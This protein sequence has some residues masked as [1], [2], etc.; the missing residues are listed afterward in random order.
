[1]TDAAID[2]PTVVT[3]S[4]CFRLGHKLLYKRY[5]NSSSCSPTTA[6]VTV[7]FSSLPESST[8][9]PF[10]QM[11]SGGQAREHSLNSSRPNNKRHHLVR[12]A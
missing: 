7:N 4:T 6:A 11:N 2:V 1:V 5:V 3:T 9:V 10:S 12:V 8:V